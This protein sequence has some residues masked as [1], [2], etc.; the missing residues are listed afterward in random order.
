MG[1]VG[2]R[3]LVPTKQRDIE[4]TVTQ[5]K[6]EVSYTF[7][8]SSKDHDPF[9]PNVDI[10]FHPLFFDE[11]GAVHNEDYIV[12]ELKWDMFRTDANHLIYKPI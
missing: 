6:Q 2:V 9:A 10:C 7:F 12:N 1:I 3:K 4:P 5:N 8:F 11:I